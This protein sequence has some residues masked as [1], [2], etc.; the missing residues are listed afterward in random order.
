MLA[1]LDFHGIGSLS[2]LIS[3]KEAEEIVYNLSYSKSDGI[4]A[5]GKTYAGRGV[6]FFSTLVSGLYRAGYALTDNPGAPNK[7]NSNSLRPVVQ[8]A[9]GGVSFGGQTITPDQIEKLLVGLDNLS[10]VGYSVV[11]VG[12][13]PS[14]MTSISPQSKSSDFIVDNITAPFMPAVDSVR[15]P[16]VRPQQAPFQLRQTRLPQTRK[17]VS[18]NQSRSDKQRLVWIIGGFGVLFAIAIGAIAS[19]K[20]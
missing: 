19:N 8:N 20:E 4:I 2:G 15:P 10:S 11:K 3:E 1:H 6:G 17:R 7:E 18:F 13:E 16:Q 9:I 14:T 5:K 12:P